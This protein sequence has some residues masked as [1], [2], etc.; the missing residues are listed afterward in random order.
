VEC[1]H[2]QHWLKIQGEHGTDLA[3]SW[4]S[5]VLAL[6]AVAVPFDS[7]PG[8]RVLQTLAIRRAK[9]PLAIHFSSALAVAVG[10]WL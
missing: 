4:W 8:K 5:A 7:L 1:L 6:A 10:A 3:V 2:H 9:F